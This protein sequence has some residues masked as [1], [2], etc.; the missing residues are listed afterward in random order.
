LY[1][2]MRVY[3]S[4]FRAAHKFQST[5]NRLVEDIRGF[6]DWM[7]RAEGLLF[8]RQ[9]LVFVRIVRGGA[10]FPILGRET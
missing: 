4:L 5:H 7:T 1:G 10:D 9:S 8:R 3:S 2:G 6:Y